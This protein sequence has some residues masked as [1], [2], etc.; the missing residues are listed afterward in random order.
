MQGRVKRGTLRQE[1]TGVHEPN[2]GLDD[3]E[4]TCRLLSGTEFAR[5]SFITNALPVRKQNTGRKRLYN[6]MKCW[7]LDWVR[8]FQMHGVGRTLTVTPYRR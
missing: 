5:A 4:A 1:R 2:S 6:P 8:L 3:N 7:Y